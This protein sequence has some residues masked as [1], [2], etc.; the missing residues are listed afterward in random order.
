MEI[1]LRCNGMQGKH[2]LCPL[3]HDQ[4]DHTLVVGLIIPV[5]PV[6]KL[7]CDRCGNFNG[8]QGCLGGLAALFCRYNTLKR[9]TPMIVL[10]CKVST[11]DALRAH[12]RCETEQVALSA[13]TRELGPFCFAGRMLAL[14][15]LC[16]TPGHMCLWIG[17]TR[18]SFAK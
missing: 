2:R 10:I 18:A 17:T 16:L 15:S 3:F 8:L 13:Y 4:E 5:Q 11:T 9:T 14:L 6:K 12:F 7:G 1:L